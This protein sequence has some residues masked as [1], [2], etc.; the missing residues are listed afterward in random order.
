[1]RFT[2]MVGLLEL[3]EANSVLEVELTSDCGLLATRYGQNVLE[4]EKCTPSISRK[5]SEIETW[6]VW[7]LYETNQRVRSRSPRIW[8]LAQG[9]SRSPNF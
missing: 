6:L 8:I 5:Q 9:R 2:A 3:E 4:A 1:M 7:L